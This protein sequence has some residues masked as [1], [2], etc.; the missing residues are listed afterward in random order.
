MLGVLQT[1]RALEAESPGQVAAKA[2]ARIAAEAEEH[3]DLVIAKA[4]GVE[5]V[6]KKP[7]VIDEKLAHVLIPEREGKAAGPAFVGA[8]KALVVVAV[9]RAIPEVDRVVVA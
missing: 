6:Q 9:L 1:A 7:G 8:V 2:G 3:T 4:V 5:F